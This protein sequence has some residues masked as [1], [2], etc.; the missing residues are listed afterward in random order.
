MYIRR[1]G[2]FPAMHDSTCETGLEKV[3]E[4][5]SPA[6]R[7]AGRARSLFICCAVMDVTLLPGTRL[8]REPG[9]FDHHAEAYATAAALRL[10][11]PSLSGSRSI[12]GAG[13]TNG[14]TA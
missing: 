7:A 3:G 4:N 10:G 8:C 9:P 11:A 2:L 12:P 13:M 5:K 6:A 14:A 1:S